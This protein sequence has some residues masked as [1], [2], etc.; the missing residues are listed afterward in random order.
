MSH[1]N[2]FHDVIVTPCSGRCGGVGRVSGLPG[3]IRDCPKTKAG[4][5]EGNHGE[6]TRHRV[7]LIRQSNGQM[8][9]RCNGVIVVYIRV[10]NNK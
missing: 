5:T 3:V 4:E 6:L 9:K 8:G 1:L 2:G 10:T 7:R